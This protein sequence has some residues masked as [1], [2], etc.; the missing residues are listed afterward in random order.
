VNTQSLPISGNHW[1]SV[2]LEANDL[3]CLK[4]QE[5]TPQQKRS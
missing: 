1:L 2:T 4:D 5:V 3:P